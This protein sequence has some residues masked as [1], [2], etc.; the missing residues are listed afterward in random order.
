[1]RADRHPWA[2]LA[3][4]ATLG[5]PRSG[6]ARRFTT[7]RSLGGLAQSQPL[8]ARFSFPVMLGRLQQELRD[9]YGV[10]NARKVMQAIMDTM[11]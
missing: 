2:P 1:V 11:K 7:Q 3:D 6:R 9:A 8:A 5:L 4:G 10:E